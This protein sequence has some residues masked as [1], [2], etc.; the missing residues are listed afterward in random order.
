M[1]KSFTSVFLDRN[2][3]RKLL[4]ES[5]LI[6]FSVLLALFINRTAENLKT[7]NQKKA[8]LERIYK[9]IQSNNEIIR[10]WQSRHTL[11][12]KR[13]D[14]IITDSNDSLRTGLLSKKYLDIDILT[15]GKGI[16]N[17]LIS[18]TAWDAAKS[19]QIMA[20]F[21]YATIETLTGLY[22]S[23]IVTLGVLD[24]ITAVYYENSAIHSEVGFE[25][26]MLKYRILFNEI[27]IQE[28]NLL[29]Y[30][31]KEALQVLQPYADGK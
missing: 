8:A 12:L 29:Q 15:G 31:Y 14:K 7:R 13:I 30:H 6:V 17:K 25:E 4:L 28:N 11:F 9:E 10:E 22:Q 3:L 27:L 1:K 21:D 18:S 20:E 24:R 26:T 23:Q 5:L 16:T 2:E 19:T